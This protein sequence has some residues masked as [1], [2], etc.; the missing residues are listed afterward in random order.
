MD[1]TYTYNIFHSNSQIWKEW[2]FLTMKG[3]PITNAKYIVA[4]LQAA[5]LPHKAAVLH[6]KEHQ[7]DNTFISISHN[8]VDTTTK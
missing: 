4:L 7:K 2:G 3:F 5:T 1:S 8:L 6:Y